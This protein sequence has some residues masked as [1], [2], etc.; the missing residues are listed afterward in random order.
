MFDNVFR[1][2]ICRETTERSEYYL[3]GYQDWEGVSECD[4]RP[5]VSDA[6][7]KYG[8]TNIIQ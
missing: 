3:G 4:F 8:K 1:E 5:L 7:K 2:I 6:V